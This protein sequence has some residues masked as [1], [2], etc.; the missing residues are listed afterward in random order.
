MKNEGIY[1]KST[2]LYRQIYYL[3]LLPIF[4]LLKVSLSMI[5]QNATVD[6]NLYLLKFNS[7]V[8]LFKISLTKG[9]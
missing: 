3:Y 4:A 1:K 6:L 2:Y 7:K 9:N 5:L 8:L